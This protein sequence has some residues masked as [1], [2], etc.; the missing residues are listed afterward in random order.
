MLRADS[1]AYDLQST[2][3]CKV[4][5][6]KC[7]WCEVKATR[8]VLVRSACTSTCMSFEC[9]RSGALWLRSWSTATW[10][11]ASPTRRHCTCT[12]TSIRTIFGAD[13]TRASRSTKRYLGVARE[14]HSAEARLFVRVRVHDQWVEPAFRFS[15]QRVGAREHERTE[16]W[17]LRAQSSL[18]AG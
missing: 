7:Q 18:I 4:L 1:D 3:Y 13:C 16:R 12:S 5:G 2:T 10:P 15:D 6:S 8:R 17:K 14:G 11:A 9:G